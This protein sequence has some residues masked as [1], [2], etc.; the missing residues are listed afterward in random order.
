[1]FVHTND[2][3]NTDEQVNQKNITYVRVHVRAD[4]QKTSALPASTVTFLSATHGTQPTVKD[5]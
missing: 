3:D 1:M 4:V 5:G 2:T